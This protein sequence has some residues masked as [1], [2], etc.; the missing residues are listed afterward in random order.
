[1]VFDPSCKFDDLIECLEEYYELLGLGDDE[2][3]DVAVIINKVIHLHNALC[4]SYVIVTSTHLPF[5]LPFSF[6]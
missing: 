5:Y 4:E 2:N 1:M 6:Q 3:I